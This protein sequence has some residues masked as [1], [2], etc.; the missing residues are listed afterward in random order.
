MDALRTSDGF[1][2]ETTL[3]DGRFRCVCRR[4][5]VEAELAITAPADAED[6][7]PLVEL[8][9]LGA[10]NL[11]VAERR[12]RARAEGREPPGYDD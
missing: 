2:F 8:L 10:R 3:E 1:E 11:W 6:I 4:E 12:M 9:E 5:G 7:R